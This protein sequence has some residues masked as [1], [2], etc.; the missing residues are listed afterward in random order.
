MTFLFTYIEAP[1]RLWLTD[2]DSM[3]RALAVHD[4]IVRAAI[5]GHG[6]YVFSTGGDG[7]AVAFS[8]AGTAIDAA[9]EAQRT[10]QAWSWPTG[11]RLRVR[12]GVATGEVWC[13]GSGTGTHLVWWGV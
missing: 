12:M 4:E 3:G 8:R 10:L 2:P 6:G 1:T 9:V 7:F 13:A 5:D 11:A